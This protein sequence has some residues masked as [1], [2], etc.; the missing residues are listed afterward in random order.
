MPGVGSG[1][2]GIVGG[3]VGT[4]GSGCGFC[5]IGGTTDVPGSAGVGTGFGFCIGLLLSMSLP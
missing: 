3:G 5:G 2:G 1:A 4:D